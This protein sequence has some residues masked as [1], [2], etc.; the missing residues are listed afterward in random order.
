M[1]QR[2]EAFE[3]FFLAEHTPVLRT[4]WLILGDRQAAEDVTQEAFYRL[5]VHW[6]KV[7]SYERPGA[8]VRRVAIRLAMRA[9]S[10]SARSDRAI[11]AAQPDPGAFID[12]RI[13]LQGLTTAQRSAVVLY[14]YE[15][16]PVSEVASL[17]RCSQGTVKTHL[18]R[19]RARLASQLGEEIDDVAR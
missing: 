3:G 18:H 17:M 16:H 5:L 12:I 8:W 6:R 2:D 7:S 14:Y 13:A 11:E 1:K 15:D 10:R 4:V 19:A 9:R